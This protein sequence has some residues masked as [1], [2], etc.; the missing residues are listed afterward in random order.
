MYHRP[1]TQDL[2][3]VSF[4][5]WF[6]KK[7]FHVAGGA[8]RDQ[9]VPPRYDVAV[10]ASELAG[11]RDDAGANVGRRLARLRIGGTWFVTSWLALAGR[12]VVLFVVAVSSRCCAVP[13]G[14]AAARPEE[15]D[16]HAWM[17]TTKQSY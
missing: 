9:L 2:Q 16:S 6:A 10:L 4:Q 14:A 15:R 1:P 13:P 11:R 12:R 5:R 17:A 3:K 8:R 7:I